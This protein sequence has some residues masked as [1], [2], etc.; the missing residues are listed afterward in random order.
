MMLTNLLYDWQK[1]QPYQ[2]EPTT[3]WDETDH[4]YYPGCK[5]TLNGDFV[6]WREIM[7][8]FD[9]AKHAL[10]YARELVREI[11]HQY[12]WTMEQFCAR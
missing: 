4:Q 6:E 5:V 12:T 11:S 9:Q 7:L 3:R 10:P 1:P 2:F 8:G